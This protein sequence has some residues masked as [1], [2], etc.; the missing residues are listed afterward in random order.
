MLRMDSE[1]NKTVIAEHMTT[2]EIAVKGSLQKQRRLLVADLME[3][4]TIKKG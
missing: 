3:L 2:E 1:N 4:I